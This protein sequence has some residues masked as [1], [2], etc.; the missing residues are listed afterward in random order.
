[1]LA[2]HPTERSV[3]DAMLKLEV[4][5]LLRMLSARFASGRAE[6]MTNV[7]GLLLSAARLMLPGRV[8]VPTSVPFTYT[9]STPDLSTT[10]ARKKSDARE[11]ELLRPDTE[12]SHSRSG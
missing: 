1:M 12:G 7:S 11:L 10:V 9:C 3:I 2:P 5:P 4:E 6:L 8:R